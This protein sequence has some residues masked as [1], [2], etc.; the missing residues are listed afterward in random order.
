MSAIRYG[1]WEIAYNPPPI[2][3]RAFDWQYSHKDFDGAEDA[4]DNRHGAEPT[5]GAVFDTIDDYEEE[6]FDDHGCQHGCPYGN[7]HMAAD[8]LKH[9]RCVHRDDVRARAKVRADHSKTVEAL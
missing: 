6:R 5:L 7:L 2:P 8:C 4:C 9:D 3:T 1:N